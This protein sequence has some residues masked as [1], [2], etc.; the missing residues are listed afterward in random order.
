MCGGGVRRNPLRIT[1][2]K[3]GACARLPK[4]RPE[5]KA[6]ATFFIL[7]ASYHQLPCLPLQDK[8]KRRRSAISPPRIFPR[9]K[10]STYSIRIH[11][12]SISPWLPGRWHLYTSVFYFLRL[13][14]LFLHV[15][16]NF[17]Y[18]H[19]VEQVVCFDCC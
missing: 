3:S 14:S 13:N 6:P 11:S 4:L 5:S 18:L 9:M 15:E 7:S 1:D 17:L 2:R 12:S 8:G 10:A 19:A 16:D